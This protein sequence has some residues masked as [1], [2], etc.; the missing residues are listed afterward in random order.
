M[1][2]SKYIHACL[3]VESEGTRILFDPGKFSFLDGGV[4][5]ES[6]R[7]L[8]AIVVTHKHLDHVDDAALAIIVRHNP[9]AVVLGNHQI[10][11]QLAASGIDVEVFESGT[12][13]VGNCTLEAIPA[14]HARILNAECPANIA[15][16]L[17]DRLLHPGDSFDPSL[18]VRKGID[19]LA[20]PVMAPWTTDLAVADFAERLA[21]KTVF[22]IH[23]GYAKD[24][25][26]QSRYDNFTKYFAKHGI[27]F[28]PLLEP[29]AALE[30]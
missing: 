29:G 28:V 23:D 18:E 21:P 25:F 19:L 4:K 24:F 30:R 7:D 14:A 6:F 17:N 20:L 11:E 5:P 9:A 15:Y 2:I 12:R 26:L 13:T 27:E 16:V 10:R 3:L 22:P 8:A 1:R